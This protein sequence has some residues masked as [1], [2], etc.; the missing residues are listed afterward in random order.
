MNLSDKFRSP[1]HLSV[2]NLG[3]QFVHTPNP[4]ADNDLNRH[5]DDYLKSC[6]KTYLKI[7]SET[8]KKISKISICPVITG[9]MIEEALGKF[10]NSSDYL[11]ALRY[12]PSIILC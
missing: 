6:R 8:G 7:I 1:D 3:L 2:L 10:Y 11:N 12:Y 4:S 5:W 9:Q